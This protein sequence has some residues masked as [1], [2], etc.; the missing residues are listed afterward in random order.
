MLPCERL[1]PRVRNSGTVALRGSVAH[2][3]KGK[4]CFNRDS[5]SPLKLVTAMTSVSAVS[6]CF[7]NELSVRSSASRLFEAAIL[8]QLHCRAPAR[9]IICGKDHC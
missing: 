2:S 7:S 5:V 6:I 9:R 3:T 4:R 1:I 8:A